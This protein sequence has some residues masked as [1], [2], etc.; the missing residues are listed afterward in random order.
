MT[1]NG[2]KLKWPDFSTEIQTPEFRLSYP[3]IWEK[4]YNELAKRE[5]YDIVMLFPKKDKTELTPIYDLMKKVA[6]FHWGPN[7]KGLKNPIKDGDTATNQAGELIKEKNQAYE[8]MMVV[9]AW[10]TKMPGVVSIKRDKEGRNIPIV[11]HDEV[12]GGCYCDAIVTCM[13]YDMAGNKGLR[14]R[15]EHVRKRRD[16]EP[17]G[18]RTKAEDAFAPVAGAE[19]A[20]EDVQDDQGMFSS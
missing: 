15:L 9:S 4:H 20:A 6:A 11:D 19:S 1:T 12:F 2:P 14:F 10:A 5:Q 16:G 13:A 17:F 18:N 3:H 8:G 7:M